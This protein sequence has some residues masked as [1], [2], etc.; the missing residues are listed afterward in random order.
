MDFYYRRYG[1]HYFPEAYER[2]LLDALNGE[3][4]LFTRS[5]EVEYAWRVIDALRNA[6]SEEEVDSIPLYA[7]GSMGPVEA[8]ELLRRDGRY[9]GPPPKEEE[10]IQEA[11]S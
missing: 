2:L 4:T 1:D 10:E 6:W 11:E 9:W 3:S 5:D 8:D 7:P